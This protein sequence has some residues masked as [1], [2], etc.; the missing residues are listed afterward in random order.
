MAR[1]ISALL[2]GLGLSLASLPARADKLPAPTAA[3]SASQNL[4]VDGTALSA[5]LFHD[6]GLE[7]R[8]SRVD[9]LN[10]LL[11][12][13]PDRQEALV[14][15]PESKVGMKLAL[16]DPEVG[17]VA[18]TLSLLSGTVE[19]TETLAGETVTRYRVQDITPD[20]SG[21]DGHVWA[22]RDGIYVKMQG[23]TGGEGAASI[24]M[25][26]TDIRRGA[27]D[28]A[29]FEAP[30]GLSIMSLD[31]LDGRVPPAFQAEKEKKAP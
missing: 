24:A 31:P 20:G 6:K 10:N 22:T 3:F 9:G 12:I 30:A 26:L 4:T 18:T 19:G 14:I 13:R 11:I 1:T 2:L 16:T 28:P 7:R 27:Q 5:R 15:Q 25:T 23:R 21:F 8:E 29:L 17:V